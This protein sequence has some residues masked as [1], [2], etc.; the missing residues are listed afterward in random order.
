[1]QMGVWGGEKLTQ[2][3]LLKV[4]GYNVFR[5]KPNTSIFFPLA[6]L[7]EVITS[8]KG[9]FALESFNL[10]VSTGKPFRGN[11]CVEGREGRRK[12][13]PSSVNVQ[14]IPGLSFLL[15]GEDQRAGV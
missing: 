12:V 6:R 15:V 5:L 7:K 2:T 8:L 13:H 1:M 4:A 3:I 14:D 9:R 11:V 10:G